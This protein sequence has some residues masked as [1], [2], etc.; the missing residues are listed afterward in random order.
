M[1]AGYETPPPSKL[2]F[3]AMY[4]GVGNLVWMDDLKL[5]A[6]FYGNGGVIAE[7]YVVS[8]NGFVCG[9]WKETFVAFEILQCQARD[10]S[11][12]DRYMAHPIFTGG[13]WD[14]PYDLNPWILNAVIAM[15][16]EH[17]TTVLEHP[18]NFEMRRKFRKGNKGSHK[19]NVL[20]PRPYYTLTIRDQVI[21]EAAQKT[22]VGL[23]VATFAYSYRFDVW[24]HE[25]CRI[26]RGELPIDPELHNTLVAR[27]YDVYTLGRLPAEDTERLASRKLMPKSVT[28]WLAIQTTW[29]NP[30]KK[31]PADAPYIPALRKV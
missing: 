5:T 3:D 31:G 23:R 13:A 30:H 4:I 10:R 15:Y 28:E 16:M 12:A 2:P 19:I 7:D 26:R 11:N 21:D 24:G 25:R 22:F 29:V 1:A 8:L 9:F 27:G 6:R 14:T 17:K 18:V 20:P